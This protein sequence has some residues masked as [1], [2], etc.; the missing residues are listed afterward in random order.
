[1]EPSS[2][3]TETINGQQRAWNVP[4]SRHRHKNNRQMIGGVAKNLYFCDRIEATLY[5]TI[6]NK[7]WNN[8]LKEVL[9]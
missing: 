9:E 4:K 5:T 6:L 7:Q 1:M 3:T 8:C 2:S